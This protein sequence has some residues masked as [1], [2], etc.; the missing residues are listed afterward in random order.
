MRKL[1]AIILS[2]FLTLM[3]NAQTTT[4][5]EGITQTTLWTFDQY[6]DGDAVSAT[7]VTNFGGLYIAGH[8]EDKPATVKRKGDSYFKFGDYTHRTN[9]YL[10]LLGS[11]S[12]LELVKTAADI[13]KDA[14]AFNADC[15]GTTYV[16]YCPSKSDRGIKVFVEGT[17]ISTPA[18]GS[19]TSTNTKAITVASFSNTEAATIYITSTAGAC[20][21]YGVKFVPDKES[22][23]T[24]TVNLGQS[25]IGTFADNHAWKMPEGMKAYYAKD[26]NEKNNQL[27]ITE[28]KDG[29]IPACTGVII[30][31]EANGVYEL[32]STDAPSLERTEGKGL[33][34]N[35]RLRPIIGEYD[36]PTTDLTT[37]TSDSYHNYILAETQEGEMV[38]T[39]IKAQTINAGNAYYSIRA[40]KDVFAQNSEGTK[41]ISLPLGVITNIKHIENARKSIQ[42]EAAYNLS[43]QKIGCNNK[44]IV[45][46]NGKKYI[47]R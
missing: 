43:G 13:Q 11:N 7:L 28:I 19:F 8:S 17:E 20:Y 3:A 9:E 44:G 18:T 27:S 25:G 39:P 31:G 32:T 33:D 34:A 38:F 36:M 45:I 29:T 5:D 12:K 6:Q 37:A 10:N 30:Q 35:Y 1:P 22:V 47:S 2:S 46:K 4:T 40:D 14:I 42:D 26:I 16:A 23:K 24:K 21:I 41:G 15:K